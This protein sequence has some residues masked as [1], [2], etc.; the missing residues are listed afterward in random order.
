MS[1]GRKTLALAL[2]LTPGIGARSLVRMLTRHDLLART[3]EELVRMAPETLIEEYGLKPAQAECWSSQ[4]RPRLDEAR[5]VEAKLDRFGV[6]LVTA[7]D[8]HYPARLEQFAPDPPG[9]L[10]V[11]GNAKLLESRTFAVMSSRDAPPAALEMI[12]H[13]TEDG[14]LAGEVLVG[15]HDKPEYQRA[16][17]VPLR[18]GA[19]RMLVLDVGLFRALG[20]ELKEEPFRTARLWRM[21]FDSAT[22]LVIS[23]VHPERERHPNSNRVRDL[24]IAGMADRIDFALIEPGGNMQRLAKMALKAGRKVRVSDMS[25]HYRE[26]RELGATIFEA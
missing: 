11:Y 14:V 6:S 20:S 8:A 17:V 23:A 13:W 16:A 10:Y 9:M 25:L 2:A 18:W 7:A 4:A 26:Y 5:Q 22:D 21:E 19:P 3:P 12:E 1:L 24:V 15:G